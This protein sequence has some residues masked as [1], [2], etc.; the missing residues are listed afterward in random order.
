MK[1]ARHT[2]VGIAGALW[3]ALSACALA[4]EPAQPTKAGGEDRDTEARPL[5]NGVPPTV[6][7]RAGFRPEDRPQYAVSGEVAWTDENVSLAEGAEL[8]REIA[9]GP[10]ADLDVQVQSDLDASTTT[11][12]E[13]WLTFGIGAN[14]YAGAVL[15]TERADNAQQF[16]LTIVAATPSEDG[17]PQLRVV[18]SLSLDQPHDARWTVRYNHGVVGVERNGKLLL[19]G[20][21]GLQALP[22]SGIRLRQP[23]LAA[24]LT[25]MSV[26]GSSPA[27][28]LTAAEV[29][30]KRELLPKWQEAQRVAQ[31]ALREENWE[32]CLKSLEQLRPL[33]ASLFGAESLQAVQNLGLLG[34]V[35]TQ[36][37]QLEQAAAAYQEAYEI[38]R[39]TLGEHHIETARAL[40]DLGLTL[41]LQRR[42]DEAIDHIRRA[43]QVFRDI[44]GDGHRETAFTLRAWA[45]KLVMADAW[46]DAAE[47]YPEAIASQR[48]V[49]EGESGA[50][51]RLREGYALALRS[52]GRQ[53]AALAQLEQAVAVWREHE[54]GTSPRTLNAQMKLARLLQDADR[55]AEARDAYES[56]AKVAQSDPASA[57]LAGVDAL[58]ALARIHAR[59][60]DVEP[61]LRLANQ[62]YELAG[63]L[64]GR[65]SF[66]YAARLTDHANLLKQLGS[67]ADSA[68]MLREAVAIFERSGPRTRILCGSALLDLM[69]AELILG[70]YAGAMRDG[71]RALDVL[72][73]AG[74]YASWQAH[75]HCLLGYIHLLEKRYDDADESFLAA[76]E[77]FESLGQQ[78]SLSLAVCWLALANCAE[79][80]EQW[81]RAF[82]FEDRALDLCQRVYGSKH[83]SIVLC[84]HSKG[85]T[86]QRQGDW[87]QAAD[88]FRQ[89]LDLELNIAVL[90]MGSVSEAEAIRFSGR[91]QT[92]RSERLNLSREVRVLGDDAVKPLLKS[93]PP[94]DLDTEYQTVWQTKAMATRMLEQRRSGIHQDPAAAASLSELATVRQDLATLLNSDLPVLS[95]DE[96]SQVLRSLTNR[97]EEIERSLA[98]RVHFVETTDALT[99]AEGLEKLAAALPAD[100][101]VIDFVEVVDVQRRFAGRGEDVT[102]RYYDAFVLRP[103]GTPPRM[104]VQWVTLGRAEP[105]D[106]LVVRWGLQNGTRGLRPLEPMTT[107]DDLGKQLSKHIWDRLAPLVK[108]ARIVFV[109]PDGRLH[110]V[111]WAG[112]PDPTAEG[113][114]LIER[115]AFVA[116]G[117]AQQLLQ[118]AEPEAS[119]AKR[120]LLVGDVDFGQRSGEP[121]TWERLP[122][123]RAEIDR[124]AELAKGRFKIRRLAEGEA[125]KAAVLADLP[126]SNWIHLAT[127]GSFLNLPDSSAPGTDAWRDL[128][129]FGGRDASA[130]SALGRNPL[131]RSRLV[132]A[133]A[134]L[135]EGSVGP[136]G[137]SILSGEEVLNCDLRSTELVVLSACETNVGVA[138]G[139]EGLFALQRAFHSAGART[140]VASLWKVEDYATAAFMEEFYRQLL[141]PGQSKAEAFRQSQLALLRR[142]DT[143]SRRLLRESN[144]SPSENAAPLPAAYW[145][146]FVLSGDW[147]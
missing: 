53:D 33:I 138:A 66:E 49:S 15:L 69:E 82:E 93:R 41:S 68:T 120:L 25:A 40:R 140:V 31:A 119:G 13:T 48:L 3:L 36:R 22:I 42:H 7:V 85:V 132:F 28:K 12:A 124:I 30:R 110:R 14:G 67:F 108:D 129:P 127:H 63:T 9:I 83:R 97:K 112:L 50:V 139:G 137:T 80:R 60:G 142:Y 8:T 91:L 37:Q 75:A 77:I 122:G 65:E 118:P 51:A 114:F 29:K 133:N 100:S 145:A 61:A 18:R 72:Q 4:D 79:E 144:T 109:I 134:N 115:F 99:G 104:S 76:A 21:T 20:D 88:L 105:L 1:I 135:A 38:C 96:R 131:L 95:P 70:D 17:Q 98:G 141:Q 47:V 24:Q 106:E 84:L 59:L 56:I 71:A 35:H 90:L 130:P 81:T 94:V 74:A 44:L 5:S 103:S 136:S 87:R 125:T 16:R 126:Q 121:P 23:G 101:V 89:S 116:V 107:Q 147:R 52:L 78:Q 128:L 32:D 143:S 46:S 58:Y 39:G 11:T 123:T 6:I 2:S 57:Q 27:S 19:M 10:V 102:K 43:A 146:A 54:G 73:Q 113:K 45:E 26:A 34:L 86:C 111:P 55:E 117:Y 64:V 92:L 62:A